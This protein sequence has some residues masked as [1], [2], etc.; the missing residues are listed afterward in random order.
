MGESRYSMERLGVLMTPEDTPEEA[1]GVLN[2]ACAR[3]RDGA[4]YLFP[5]LV[6]EG[7]LSRVGRA[8]VLVD[9]D[10]TPVGVERLG[11]VLE[12][13]EAWERNART[14]GVED[15]RITYVPALDRYVMTYAAYGPLASRVGLAVSED[16]VRWERLGPVW[17]A[18]DPALRTDLNLYSNKDAVLFPE[19]VPGP[20]GEPAFAMLHRPSW[21]LSW[22][23]AGEGAPLP[24]GVTD[25][26]PGIWASFASAAEVRGDL[27]RLTRF[28]HHRQVALPERSWEALKI[29]GGTPPVRVADGWLTIHHGVTGEAEPG[30]DHQPNVRYCAGAMV[31]DPDDV[32]RV[33]HRSA[34]PLLEPDRPEE[35]DGIVPNVVFPTAIDVVTGGG[36]AAAAGGGGR[37]GEPF[38]AHVFYGMAD[39]RIGVARL[40]REA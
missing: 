40:C 17:F 13:E 30:R 19:P 2:P 14:A 38:A 12:P 4:L 33:A 35:R 3:G 18:Y 29:G 22:F 39:S 27:R 5:R 16:L 26:R 32:T 36:A 31:L 28:E 11:V 10:G 9:D 21:D 7:N 24:E 20:D 23:A 25:S 6:A 34:D 15:P 37:N 8:R 1:W